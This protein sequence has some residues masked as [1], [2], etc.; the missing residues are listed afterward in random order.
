MDDPVYLD[1]IADL[2]A[3]AQS[4]DGRW[5]LVNEGNHHYSLKYSTQEG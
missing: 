1:Y 5:I 3:R 4:R 2:I